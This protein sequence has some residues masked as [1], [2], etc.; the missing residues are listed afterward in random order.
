MKRGKKLNPR[1]KSVL[2][3]VLKDKRDKKILSKEHW[4][5]I[6]TAHFPRRKFKYI[7]FYQPA[8]FGKSGKRIEYYAKVL[9]TE[10]RRR[11]DLIPKEQG[12][13]RARDTYVKIVVGDLKKLSRPI[14][15]IIPRRI[16]FGFTSLKK[17]LSSKNIL[18]LYGVLPTEITIKRA[19]NRLGVKS[20]SE[21]AVSRGGKRYRL[22]LV[23]FCKHGNIAI[24]CDNLKA[25]STKFQTE[26]DKKKDKFLKK[27]GWM[28]VRL[29]EKDIVERLD[30]CTNRVLKAV[31]SFG[32]L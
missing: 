28:V 16:S 30:F 4:Y 31:K 29:K 7:A 5:R 13:P 1:N 24:E 2:V 21:H 9:K 32:G 18:E 8:I 27:N 19:L 6:P 17:L 22:D 20:I 3:G 10:V 25:H 26:K 11:I 15:N 14:R 12:H 23:V